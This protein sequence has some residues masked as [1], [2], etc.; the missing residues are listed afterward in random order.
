MTSEMSI[1]VRRAPLASDELKRHLL[2]LVLAVVLVWYTSLAVPTHAAT[3]AARAPEDGGQGGE[4]R[5]RTGGATEIEGAAARS[6]VA[7][8]AG[9]SVEELD[10]PE[11]ICME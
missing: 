11:Y 6:I 5:G 4:V 2:A 9:E 8:D 10:W 7:S 1:G 3:R